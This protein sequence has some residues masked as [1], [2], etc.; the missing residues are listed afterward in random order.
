MCK[1]VQTCMD[2]YGHMWMCAESQSKVKFWKWPLKLS[3]LRPAIYTVLSLT[4]KLN[5]LIWAAPSLSRVGGDLSLTSLQ[6]SSPD[7]HPLCCPSPW[8]PYW[9]VS[10]GGTGPLFRGK[11]VQLISSAGNPRFSEL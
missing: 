8:L 1:Y 3:L 7:A 6:V 2:M 10:T 9:L 4:D 5:L 11:L